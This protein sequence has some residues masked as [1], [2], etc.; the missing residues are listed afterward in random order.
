VKREE[1][2]GAEGVEE[3]LKVQRK[4]LGVG[5][6]RR[7]RNAWRGIHIFLL[8]DVGFLWCVFTCV[9]SEEMYAISYLNFSCVSN[10]YMF[11]F[12]GPLMLLFQ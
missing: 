9:I 4:L 8:F 7:G 6:R 11:L 2:V 3:V 1:E 12:L 10:D 5:E